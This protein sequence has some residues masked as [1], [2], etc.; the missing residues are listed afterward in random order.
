MAYAA[1]SPCSARSWNC[2][3]GEVDLNELVRSAL[4]ALGGMIRNKPVL[5]LK[6]VPKFLVEPRSVQSALINLLLNAQDAVRNGGKIQV[7][8]EVRGSFAA[9]SVSDEGCG[10]SKEFIDRSL[11]RPFKTTKN[12]GMGIGL[13]H[14]RK[15]IE[16]H[17]GRIEVESAEGKGS[18]LKIF[19]R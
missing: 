9:L 7:C 14:G 12:Q 3:P 8:T 16:A 2:A 17:Q 4:A 1:S 19:S 11:F 18:T 5:D 13:F 10:M 6:P 15:I